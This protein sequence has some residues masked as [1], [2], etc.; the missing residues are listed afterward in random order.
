MQ[1]STLD[2]RS[3]HTRIVLRNN[4]VQLFSSVLRVIDV[5]L[6]VFYLIVVN[7]L[8]FLLVIICQ[9]F[10][11]GGCYSAA[12]TQRGLKRTLFCPVDAVSRQ[13]NS[14]NSYL[15]ENFFLFGAACCHGF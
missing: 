11:L 1:A 2:I 12:P 8:Q 14:R 9:N 13:P 6:I 5:I 3:A 15:S 4:S 7:C 10:L